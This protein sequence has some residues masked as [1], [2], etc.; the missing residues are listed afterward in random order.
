MSDTKHP[1]AEYGVDPHKI[2]P[3]AT[4]SPSYNVP[5]SMPEPA[6]SWDNPQLPTPSAQHEAMPPAYEDHTNQTLSQPQPPQPSRQP[7]LVRPPSHQSHP[8]SSRASASSTS[9]SQYNTPAC[10][11][12]QAPPNLTYPDFNPTFLIANGDGEHIHKAFPIAVPPSTAYPH[13]FQSHGVLEEDWKAF[14]QAIQQK[15]VI[16]DEQKSRARIPII[17]LIP[18]V[19]IIVREG[20]TTLMKSRKVHPVCKLIHLWNH[21]YFNPRRIEVILMQ[22]NARVDQEKASLPKEYE[23]KGYTQTAGGSNLNFDDD[24]TFRLVVR[25]LSAPSC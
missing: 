21:H 11:S 5:T 17:S 16:S 2:E 24:K 6:T 18:V 12:R 23:N 14:L 9:S 22:G 4:P 1:L 7:Q 8:S 10:F 19:N 25:S 15:A 20:I 3:D 13:P